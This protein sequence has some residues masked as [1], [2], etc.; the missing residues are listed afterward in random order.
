MFPFPFLSLDIFLLLI[1]F[2][3]G[4]LILSDNWWNIS[5]IWAISWWIFSFEFLYDSLNFEVNLWRGS[6]N[7]VTWKLN[8]MLAWPQPKTDQEFLINMH[9]F[10]LESYNMNETICQTV[11]Y[12]TADVKVSWSCIGQWYVLNLYLVK[13]A[14]GCL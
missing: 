5:Q 11:V 3:L 6:R 10:N 1:I 8:K 2:S 7:L 14:H 4:I 9:D 13:P 12:F